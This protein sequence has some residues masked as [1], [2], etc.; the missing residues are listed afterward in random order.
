[1]SET[2]R[3]TNGTTN[4]PFSE[5]L[6]L[7]RFRMAKEKP[8][9]SEEIRL[10][11]KWLII[12]VFVLFVIA[13][14]IFQVVIAQTGRPW[15]EFDLRT[16]QLLAAAIV[17]GISIAASFFLFLIGYV[18]RDAKRRGMNSTLWTLL[19]IILL[20]A[21][22]FT[23]FIP[24]SCPQCGTAISAR[25]NYCPECKFN[26]HPTCPQC[27]REVRLGNHY[28]PHCSQELAAGPT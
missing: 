27:R 8:K 12:L 6:R 10:I 19:V 24:Y 13:Q 25:F 21:Y 16:R 5:K 17:T 20:P 9:F 26:L 14:V 22:L 28:C 7:I 4:T 15:P 11:P 3:Y 1:M 23:G 2:Q 18:S